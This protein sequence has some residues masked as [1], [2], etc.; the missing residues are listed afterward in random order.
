MSREENRGPA[1]QESEPD[2]ELPVDTMVH[3]APE[4]V[5]SWLDMAERYYREAVKRNS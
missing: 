3:A 1:M 2:R 4:R 5:L